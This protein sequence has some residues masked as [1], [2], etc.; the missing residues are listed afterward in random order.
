MPSN[1]YEISTKT[2]QD[3]VNTKESV[4]RFQ[5]SDNDDFGQYECRGTS[6][7]EE[8]IARVII[9]MENISNKKLTQNTL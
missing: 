9:K 7:S 3:D 1:K 5:T 4:L 2:V 6:K 8:S